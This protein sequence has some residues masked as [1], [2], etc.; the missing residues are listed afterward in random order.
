MLFG[1]FVS[2]AKFKSKD[3]FLTSQYNV[4]LGDYYF[5]NDNFKESVNYYNKS[6][7]LFNKYPDILIGAK[8]SLI[9]A[10]I[11]LNDI[12]KAKKEADSV[13]EDD[14][15]VQSTSMFKSYLMS[16]YSFLK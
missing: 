15:S 12:S 7:K 5:N 2:F 14:L 1:R 3:L 8:I 9:E 11:Q 13:N 4:L 10:Y 6:L 16:V